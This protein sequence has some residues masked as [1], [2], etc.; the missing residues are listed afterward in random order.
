[1]E[2]IKEWLKNMYLREIE[3]TKYDI[4][5]EHLWELGYDG[6][7]PNPHTENIERLKEYIEILNE[8]LEELK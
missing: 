5:N 6:E 7:D 4:Q 8:K 1:M 3:D 2:M